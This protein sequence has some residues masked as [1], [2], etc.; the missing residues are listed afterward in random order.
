IIIKEPKLVEV[1]AVK[2]FNKSLFT[3]C[4]KSGRRNENGKTIIEYSI[5]TTQPSDQEWAWQQ[6]PFQSDSPQ[7]STVKYFSSY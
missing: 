7:W 6:D 1:E 2:V 5:R 4:Q 3:N